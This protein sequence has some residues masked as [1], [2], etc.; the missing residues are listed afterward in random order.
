MLENT[1]RNTAPTLTLLV[2][3]ALQDGPRPRAGDPS[4]AK[5]KLGRTLDI[6]V[7]QMCAAMVAADFSEAQRRALLKSQGYTVNVS[8]E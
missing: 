6:T 2:L 3:A 4:K 7:Q 8:I 5:A 1:G